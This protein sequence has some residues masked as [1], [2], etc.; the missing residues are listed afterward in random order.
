MRKF[1]KDV[2]CGAVLW[3]PPVLLHPEARDAGYSDE[4]QLVSRAATPSFYPPGFEMYLCFTMRNRNGPPYCDTACSDIPYG[5]LDKSVNYIGTTF[6][7]PPSHPSC[8]PSF[9]KYATRPICERQRIRRKEVMR[10]SEYTLVPPTRA[11]LF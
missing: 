2:C 10:R 1:I 5:Q 4:Q 8:L 7:A 6:A 11:L 3:R 9:L